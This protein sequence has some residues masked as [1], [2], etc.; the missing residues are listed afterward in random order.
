MAGPDYM[1]DVQNPFLEGLKGYQLAQTMALQRQQI[2]QQQQAQ[3]RQYD[4]QTALAQFSERPGKTVEDY[5]RLMIRFPE[6]SDQLQKNIAGLTE[7]Q[8]QGKINKLMPIYAALKSGNNEIASDIIDQEIAGAKY[9]ADPSQA[10]NLE[11]VKQNLAT[12][13][14]GALTAT[15]L[16]LYGAMG[17][18]Q[19][20]DM[21][22]QLYERDAKTP[23]ANNIRMSEF[24]PDK[25]MVGVTQAGDIVVKDVAGNRITGDA[26]K[27]KIDEALQR[28]IDLRGE[29]AKAE[30][31]A[32]Q[33]VAQVQQYSKSVDSINSDITT[34]KEAKSILQSAIDEGRFTGTGPIA[35]YLPALT[36]TSQEL[37]N[38]ARRM[39]LGIISSTTFGALSEGELKLAM[40][41]AFPKG[42]KGQALLD[43]LQERIDAKQK[44]NDQMNEAVQFLGGGG[45]V[46]QWRAMQAGQQKARAKDPLDGQRRIN[47]QTG[48][49]IVRQNGQW[50]DV[51][52]GQP[53]Q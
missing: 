6:L 30:A 50:I 51:K 31:E 14:R 33:A 20:A 17:E 24:L 9:G 3:Q 19:F 47:R 13:P 32:R 28:G 5:R 34:L 48:Q 26:A 35:Q 44:L 16:F 49:E 45:T 1:I 22:K 42:L 12:D 11:I 46:A 29:A 8:R 52:T 2:Q 21:D 4:M 39:G 7:E 38:V 18:K 43:W 53:L 23:D 25:T 15:R 36:D 37:R 40:D 10:K 41:T 27:R